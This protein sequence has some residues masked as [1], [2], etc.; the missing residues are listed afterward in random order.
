MIAENIK[1]YRKIN[2]I[3]QTEL[4]EKLNVAQTA[5][6]QWETGTRTPDLQTLMKM[7]DIFGISVD[8]LA[9]KENKC[10]RLLS[11]VFP[12][13]E[14]AKSLNENQLSQWLS[15][16]RWLIET[17]KSKDNTQTNLSSAESE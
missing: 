11:D 17:N 13:I 7:A 10:T 9:G 3:S 15:F 4:G 8:T 12:L 14:I 16:G 5:V 1:R 6:S 2:R